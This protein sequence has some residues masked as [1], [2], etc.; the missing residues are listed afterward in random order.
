[1]GRYGV[2]SAYKEPPPN[3]LGA[4]TEDEHYEWMAEILPEARWWAGFPMCWEEV[5][6]C[7]F[8]TMLELGLW[9]QH[10]LLDIGAGCLDAGRLFMRHLDVGN[11]WFI[12]PNNWMVDIAYAAMEGYAVERKAHRYDFEDFKFTRL[13][14][15]FDFILAHSI[16]THA[17]QA[18]V[19]I[20]MKEAYKSLCAKEHAT[21]VAT[22]YGRGRVNN[23]NIGW[24]S[25]SGVVYTAR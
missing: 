17:S 2:A 4:R 14:K 15:K 3:M 22:F 1:M 18:Q 16:F 24:T 13:N 7:Q 8:N 9:S 23:A 5:A 12:E 6:Y 21:F 20:I 10:S 19:K 25:P 11:Y